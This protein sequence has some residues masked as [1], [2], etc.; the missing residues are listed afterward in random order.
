MLINCDNDLRNV[1]S[2]YLFVV[3]KNICTILSLEK[4]YFEFSCDFYHNK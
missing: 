4:K 1:R 3:V 2:Q